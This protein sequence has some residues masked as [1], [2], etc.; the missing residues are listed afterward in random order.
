[1]LKRICEGLFLFIAAGTIYALFV[2]ACALDD[3][4]STMNGMQ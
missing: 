1:M 2:F 4:C 3:A